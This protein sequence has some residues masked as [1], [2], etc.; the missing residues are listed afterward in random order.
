MI[1]VVPVCLAVAIGLSNWKECKEQNKTSEHQ[2]GITVSDAHRDRRPK[3]KVA[4]HPYK[5]EQ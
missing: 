3:A 1:C 2:I 5:L 4:S